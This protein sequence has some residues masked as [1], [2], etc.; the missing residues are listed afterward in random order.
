MS[1]AAKAQAQEKILQELKSINHICSQTLFTLEELN[2]F[3]APDGP[4][5]TAQKNNHSNPWAELT[6]DAKDD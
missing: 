5:Q 3:T 6:A 4:L 1:A 2:R